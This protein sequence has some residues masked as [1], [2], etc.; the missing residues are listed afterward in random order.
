[1]KKGLVED[2]EY[3]QSLALYHDDLIRFARSLTRS[4]EDAQ[5]LVSE[6]ILKSFESWNKLRDHKTFRVYLFRIAHRLYMR[7]QWR[8]RLFNPWSE[9]VDIIAEDLLPD[10]L[11]DVTIIREALQ[12][13]PAKQRECFVLF[14]V[15]GLSLAEIAE[16]QNGSI[17]SIKSRLHRAKLALRIVLSME[18]DEKNRR[19]TD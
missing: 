11:T 6:T 10:A 17:G 3:L 9:N 12:K 16:V 5:D 7:Q 4:R 19:T 1:M 2:S 13:L 18:N 14:H 8:R 15:M